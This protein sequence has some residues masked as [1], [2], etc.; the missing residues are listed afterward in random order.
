MGNAQAP[1]TN[2]SNLFTTS[3][4]QSVV[5]EPERNKR[6]CTD[7]GCVVGLKIRRQIVMI[8]VAMQREENPFC[9]SVVTQ[10]LECHMVHSMFTG[11][12]SL[13]RFCLDFWC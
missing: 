4:Q 1:G 8:K 5:Q 3:L 6:V 7:S 13:L 12:D 10:S 2:S 11:C 9:S